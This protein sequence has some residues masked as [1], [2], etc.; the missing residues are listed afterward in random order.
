M[1]YVSLR[2]FNAAGATASYTARIIDPETHLIPNVL[3]VAA[4]RSA[5]RRRSSERTTTRP[6][7]TCIR[8]YIHVQRPRGCA[9]AGAWSDGAGAV[10][11]YN[12]GYGSG[13]SVAE[14]VE[15]ARQVTGCR[16][17]TESAPRRAG[18]PPMLIASSDRIMMDLG[19]QPRLSEL[20]QIL[21]SAWQLADGSARGADEASMTGLASS[22]SRMEKSMRI[23]SGRYKGRRLKTLDGSVDAPD[24]GPT[25]G[26]GLQH[27]LLRRSRGRASLISAPV[28]ER[29]GSK[30][31][32]AEPARVTF[33]EQSPKAAAIIRENL[34]HCAD[35][36]PGLPS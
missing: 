25:A 3:K 36:R 35:H 11:T 6:D 32:R 12:L 2:Y 8:D 4:G 22:L 16:I 15:M 19:W 30:R 1:R 31:S 20:D 27:S 9:S 33:V 5:T 23:I 28:R 18:D 17:P 14:V 29:S 13:Y 24:L 26:N 10:S 34:A 7:G 21:E